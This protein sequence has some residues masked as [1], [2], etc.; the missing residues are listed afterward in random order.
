MGYQRPRELP[1]PAVEGT[2]K[3]TIAAKL[4]NQGMRRATTSIIIQM[5][6]GK[7]AL[8][9]Y[10]STFITMELTECSC[11]R[12]QQ[13]VRHMLLHCTNRSGPRARYLT[14]VSRRELDYWSYLIRPDL[15]P[16]AV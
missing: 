7:I 13:G 14:Q 4:L 9:S 6:V 16:K 5:Q 15:P 12:S 11:G 2:L 3:G 1:P 10:L 8:T